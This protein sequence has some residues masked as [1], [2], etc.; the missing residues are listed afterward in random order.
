MRL[1]LGVRERLNSVCIKNRTYLIC[2][3][4]DSGR[5]KTQLSFKM[6]APLNLVVMQFSNQTFT[7]KYILV[8]T[9]ITLEKTTCKNMFIRR[10]SH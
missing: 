2:T 10:K 8:E 1:G 9:C 7:K 3:A 5:T 4:Q 6:C